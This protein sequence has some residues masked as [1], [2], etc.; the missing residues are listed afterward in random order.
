MEQNANV[1]VKIIF[2]T[3]NDEAHHAIK[4]TRHL[5]A[6][7]EDSNNEKFIQQSLGD[8][9]LSETKDYELFAKKYEMNGELLKQGD[10]IE[11]M[12]KWCKAMEI[13][14]TPT[15]F[16]N[17]QQLPDAYSIEDLKYFLLE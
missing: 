5:V 15:I 10:K 13:G 11:A 7:A 8:W 1:K 14:F 16:L 6:I 12:D 2:N 9:Y 3:P 4:P 17:G